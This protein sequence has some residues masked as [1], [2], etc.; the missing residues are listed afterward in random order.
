MATT[1]AYRV[2]DSA[3]KVQSGTLE[4][5]STSL[6]AN[7]LREMGYTPI[8]ID[9][10]SSVSLKSDITIPGLSNRVKLKELSLF[11]RQFATM[12]NSGL[13]LLRAL[14]ILGSQTQSK[15]FAGVIDQVRVDIEQG[16][17]LSQ[18]M[19]KHPKVFNQ[20]FVS[21]IKAGESGGSLDQT[22]MKLA[23][24]L[25]KQVELRGRIRSAMAYPVATLALVSL[26]MTAMLLFVIPVFAK[27]YNGLGGTLPLPTRIVLAVSHLMITALPAVVVGVVVAVIGFKKWIATPAGRFAFDRA[28]LRAPVFGSLVQKTA[29]ARYASTFSTLMRSG[30]PLLDGIEITKQTVSN[31]VVANGLQAMAD[32]AKQGEPLTSRLGEHTVFPTMVVQMMSV[33]EETGAL[34]ELLARIA[35]F[36]EQEVAT[37]VDALTSMLEPL[38][39]VVLGG[40]VGSMVV[41]MYMP[42]F[43]I[44]KLIK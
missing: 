14:S 44:I 13:T 31:V 10:R 42:M 21:M 33:G 15:F 20:L 25:E 7:K 35:E 16:A 36:Y 28:K 3:G 43:N 6:V 9:E 2:R 38:M 40:A 27:M 37:A 17:S 41:A 4:A 22:L 18:A 24:T 30:V 19:A 8:A 11:C 23:D 26:I 12:I 32:G 34:D 39:I 1:Y 5:D 29:M